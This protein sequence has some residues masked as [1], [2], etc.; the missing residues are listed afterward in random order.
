MTNS[1]KSS[2]RSVICLQTVKVPP[3]RPPAKSFLVFIP[4]LFLEC[5]TLPHLLLFLLPEG[6]GPPRQQLLMEKIGRMRLLLINLQTDE[7]RSLVPNVHAQQVV[8]MEVSAA[9]SDL[10]GQLWQLLLDAVYCQHTWKAVLH[11]LFF[12]FLSNWLFSM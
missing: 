2:T 9:A 10:M 4:S 8:N 5:T 7:A 3:P 1:P 6:E 11:L 12:R